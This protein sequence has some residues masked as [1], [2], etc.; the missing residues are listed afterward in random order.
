MDDGPLI[1]KP[2]LTLAGLQ[3]QDI[4]E[5]SVSDLHE[6]ISAMESEI[7]RCRDAIKSRDATRNAA[8]QLFKS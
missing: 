2:D 5:M 6:R 4:S 8:E 3:K 1:E 7:K